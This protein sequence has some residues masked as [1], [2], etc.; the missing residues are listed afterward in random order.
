MIRVD[1]KRPAR[2]LS[3][4]EARDDIERTLISLERNRLQK[5]WVERLKAKSF[6]TTY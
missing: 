5:R 3:L 4:D 6:V 1:E 2:T